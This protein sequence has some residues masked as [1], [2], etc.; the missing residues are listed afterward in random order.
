MKTTIRTLDIATKIETREKDGKKYISGLIP[1]NSR[2]ENLG[3]FIEIIDRSAFRKTL[4]DGADVFAFWA[5]NE[6][7]ILGSTRAGT[8]T[9][10]DREDGLAFSIE[11]R[12][13]AMGS[14]RYEAVRRGDV[15][16][17]SF[18]FITERDEWNHKETPALRTLKEVRLMEISPGVAFPAYPGA[19][20]SA[21]L[22]SVVNEM[23]SMNEIPAQAEK[24]TPAP[25]AAP[26]AQAPGEGKRA[27]AE[28]LRR[29]QEDELALM[30]A[31]FGL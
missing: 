19:Q 31:R 21:S 3:G 30:R 5:H 23:R 14:D 13:T 18:G 26:P 25:I 6:A 22:R 17:T 16:G 12:D 8:M 20:S 28:V 4:S 10:E 29:R 2:S 7:E 1:Y 15:L 11:V 27:E 24:V 9:L